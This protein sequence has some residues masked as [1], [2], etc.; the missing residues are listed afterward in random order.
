M[1]TYLEEN[2]IK[3]AILLLAAGSSSRLGFPKA[4]VKFHQKKL[5]QHLLEEFNKV[6]NADTFVVTGCHHDEVIPFISSNVSIVY[7]NHWQQGM[8]KSIA[9]GIAEIIRREYEYVIICMVD[10]PFVNAHLLNLMV[11]FFQAGFCKIIFTDYGKQT[12]PPVLFGKQY[13]NR[14]IELKGDSGAKDIIT[15]NKSDTFGIHYPLAKVDLD[16]ESDVNDFY[17]KV[18]EE[19]L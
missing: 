5:I 9:K 15:A 6:F 16:T 10:Q 17:R 4:L 19:E 18:W 13:F 14:L 11:E 3:G 1:N 2:R 8:G 7:N 12:G